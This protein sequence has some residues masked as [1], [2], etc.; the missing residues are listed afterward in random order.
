M[1]CPHS[2]KAGRVYLA[3]IILAATGALLIA[4]RTIGGLSSTFGFSMLVVL[5]LLTGWK[6]YRAIRNGD[7]AEHR[8]WMIR[9]YALTFAGVTLRL[10]FIALRVLLQPSLATSYGNSFDALQLE[11]YRTIAWLSWVPNLVVAEWVWVRRTKPQRQAADDGTRASRTAA[12][13]SEA[14]ARS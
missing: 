11:V 10:W 12:S 5:W 14:I 9:N 3:A 13:A 7:V 2:A 6:A 4:S 8:A 1:Y